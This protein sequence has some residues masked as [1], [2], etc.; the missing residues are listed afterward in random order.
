MASKGPSHVQVPLAGPDL[1]GKEKV[2]VENTTMV[3]F[4]M[5]QI[6]S[7]RIVSLEAATLNP[8]IATAPS[9]RHNTEAIY[10]NCSFSH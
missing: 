6:Y 7:S 8:P 9:R 1:R 2:V 4:L 10:T 3:R 5:D